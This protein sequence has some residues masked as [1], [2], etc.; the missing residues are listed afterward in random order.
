MDG[1]PHVPGAPGHP[2]RHAPVQCSCGKGE[3][4]TL[5]EPPNSN[6]AAVDLRTRVQKVDSLDAVPVGAAIVLTLSVRDII[7][8]ISQFAALGA[9]TSTLACLFSTDE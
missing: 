9:S 7:S 4:A 5:A 3:T 2:L 6:A 8:E 1:L